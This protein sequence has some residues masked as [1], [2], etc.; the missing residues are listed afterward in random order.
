MVLMPR[1]QQPSV[2]KDDHYGKHTYIKTPPKWFKSK[3]QNIKKKSHKHGEVLTTDNIC[4]LYRSDDYMPQ[5][6]EYDPYMYIFEQ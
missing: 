5:N 2:S 1:K 3:Q 4:P 6:S